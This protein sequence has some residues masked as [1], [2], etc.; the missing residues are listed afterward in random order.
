MHLPPLAM[1]LMASGDERCYVELKMTMQQL[2]A[3]VN[4]TIEIYEHAIGSIA[5]RTRQI[6]DNY[7]PVDALAKLVQSPDLQKGF[8]A[9]RDRNELDRTFESVIIRHADLFPDQ[10]IKAA[11]WRLDNPNVA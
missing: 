1:R 6:I 5:A 8:K 9:L 10:V 7:G 2:I 3:E 4:K 11:Q